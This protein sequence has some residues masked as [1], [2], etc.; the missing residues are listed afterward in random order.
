[1][2]LGVLANYSELEMRWLG[3]ASLVFMTLLLFVQTAVSS[4]DFE[5]IMVPFLS[6]IVVGFV[7][8]AFREL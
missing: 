6:I 1:M 2:V 8:E 7:W 3:F 5:I 4:L